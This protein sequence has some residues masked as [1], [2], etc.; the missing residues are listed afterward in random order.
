MRRFATSMF[1]AAAAVFTLPAAAQAQDA[2]PPADNTIVVEGELPD[3]GVAIRRQARDVTQRLGSSLTPLSRFRRPVCAGV[4]GLMTENAATVIDR[5]Y[6]NAR[7][8]DIAV[9]PEAGCDANVWV[10]VTDDAAASF[11]KLRDENNWMVRELGRSERNAVEK[12]TGPVRAWNVSSTRTHEGQVVQTGFDAV[13]GNMLSQQNG[14]AGGQ[15]VVP[16]SNMSRSQ[17]AVRRDIDFSVVLVSRSAM[18]EIDAHAL[19]DYATMRL[20]ATT[21]EP[22]QDIAYDTVLTLFSDRHS[23]D[24]LTAFD[25]SYLRSLYQGEGL[26]NGYRNLSGLDHLMAEELM[27]R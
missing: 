15:P 17:S 18:A 26:R 12:Q 11:A 10:I 22:S 19:A 24:R 2:V 16:T 3:G 1:L 5:I 6:E 4:W 9:N 25:I 27:R 14:N 7:A 20:L 8:A 21:E 23:A 13:A